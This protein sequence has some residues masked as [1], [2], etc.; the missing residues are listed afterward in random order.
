MGEAKQRSRA[1]AE[2]LQ[3]EVQCVYCD[4][5]PTTVEHMPPTSMFRNKI[6]LSGLEFACCETCNHSTSA[7]DAAASFF[8]RLSPTHQTDQNE[9]DEAYALVGTLA[10]RAPGA[11]LE[12][13]DEQ[14]STKIWAKGRSSI[15]GQMHSIKLD[16]PVTHSLMTA[17]TAKFGMAMFR[18]HVG[19]AMNKGGVYTQFYFNA[20]L[21]RE[22]AK[23]TVSILPL[24]GQLTMGKQRSGRQFNYRYNCDLKSIT[25]TFG[26]FHDN[27]FVR[28]IAVED[29]ESYRFLSD[30]Y[31]ADFVPFAGLP[32]LARIWTA[33]I[34]KSLK[35]S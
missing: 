13:F 16:G 29:A 30:E 12:I 31:N 23:A 5:E 6:R 11:I 8:A 33:P 27:L 7:S 10:Q 21:T 26:A 35:I 19:R 2:I 17:F 9:L 18:E 1:K 22:V 3:S 24:F 20:G 15:Y 28:A 32:E 34:P 14:K 4:A 25:A